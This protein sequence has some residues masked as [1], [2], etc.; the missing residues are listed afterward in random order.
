MTFCVGKQYL[1]QYIVV[2]WE[3]NQMSM[4]NLFFSQIF[5]MIASDTSILGVTRNCKKVHVLRFSFLQ[6]A[7][8]MDKHTPK[9]RR[10]ERVEQ[11]I[12][13][14]KIIWHCTEFKL[15]KNSYH[16]FCQEFLCHFYTQIILNLW[17][18]KP[19]WCD[20]PEMGLLLHEGEPVLSG[21]LWG[22]CK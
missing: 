2:L 17:N 16:K 18:T 13:E 4:K 3:W 14:V 8:R 11:V 22:I 6:A 12:L 7:L 5:K 1:H 19:D 20:C 15:C 9:E 21:H 10:Q